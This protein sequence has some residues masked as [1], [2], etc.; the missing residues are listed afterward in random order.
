VDISPLTDEQLDLMVSYIAGHNSV[1]ENHIGFYG[2]GEVDVREALGEFL[3]PLVESFLLAYE[4]D[5][6]VGVFGVDYDSEVDRAWLYGPLVTS[7]NWHATA[8][9]LYEGIKELIPSS[10]HTQILF[11]DVRN[12][13]GSAF[14][15]RQTFSLSSENAVFVLQRDNYKS[16][17]L[18]YPIR[19]IIDFQGP[20]FAQFD[21][22]HN[23]LFPHTNFTSRQ[24]VEKLDDIHRLFLAVESGKVLGYHFCKIESEGGYIEL[25]GV[26]SSAR[27]Q[28]IGETLLASGVDWMLSAPSTKKI[29]LTVNADNVPAK[30]LYHKFGFTTERVMRGYRRQLP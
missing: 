27:G 15:E 9:A 11:F 13:N 30:N 20:Y 18:S 26:D 21:V 10:I 22:L 12:T 5:E 19:Q 4:G 1:G 23:D 25:I 28:R 8:D 17:F 29:R 3:H 14:A 24:I 16:N 7:A 2:D 6:I